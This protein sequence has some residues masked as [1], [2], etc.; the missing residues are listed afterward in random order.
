MTQHLPVLSIIVLFF[1]AFLTAIIGNR[2]KALRIIIVTAATLTS[3]IFIMLL[4]KPILIEG[5]I[6][7]Y[8]MGNWDPKS[9]F[10]IGIGLEI[11]GLNLMFGVIASISSLISGIYSF[12][13]MSRDEALD[14]Y[15]ILFLMLSGSVLGIL[16]TGDLFNMFIMIVLMTF[17]EVGLTAFRNR[18]E[19]ALEA[20]FK[21]LVVGSLA[22]ALIL[23]GIIML[24]AQ[25]HTLNMAQISAM[26]HNNYTPVTLFA[27]SALIGGFSVKAYLIPSHAVVPDGCQAAPTPISMLFSGMVNMA[28]VYGIIRLVFII[29]TSMNLTQMRLMFV[30]W[31]TVT[32]LVGA[33]MALRQENLKR[34]LAYH[35]ISQ[36]GYVFIGVGLSTVPGLTGGLY[37]ALN[38]TLFMGLLFLCAG[39]VLYSIGT[40]D[41]KKLGGIAKKMPQTALIFII[42]A[43]SIVGLPPFNGFVTKSIINRAAID[44]GYSLVAIIALMTSLVTLVSFIKVSRL[45]F[46]GQLPDEYQG[47]IEAPLSMRIPMWVMAILCLVSGILPQYVIKYLITPAVSGVLNVGNYIDTMMGTGYAEKWFGEPL[48]STEVLYKFPEYLRIVPLICLI[49]IIIFVL[50]A[51]V[52]ALKPNEWA[53]IYNS[54]EQDIIYNGEK[55]KNMFSGAI[56]ILKKS[57]R[58]F[59]TLLGF[60]QRSHSGL[61]NDYALWVV[62]TTAIVLV[63]LFIFV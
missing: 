14:K 23:L 33:I 13:Y 41:L 60:L 11:D 27:F 8:W 30:I 35:C 48:L 62:S 17:A 53:A 31:G 9:D 39:A 5:N 25:F 59:E 16:F 2:N 26:L 34:L 7:T 46:Y 47:V 28:G 58:Y 12:K 18:S 1:G 38:E 19:G 50:A 63:Y 55:K 57:K 15:Y 51:V 3:F 45:V 44:S 43:L 42:G 37:H 56:G 49:V 32:M 6:M 61:I 4:I 40:T 36:I 54:I 20:A 29:Y 21:L 22:L 24:Y 52:G 10:A